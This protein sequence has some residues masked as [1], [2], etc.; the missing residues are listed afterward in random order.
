M[1]KIKTAIK[2]MAYI[3]KYKCRILDL[4]TGTVREFEEKLTPGAF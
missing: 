3:R 1:N 2:I 4:L